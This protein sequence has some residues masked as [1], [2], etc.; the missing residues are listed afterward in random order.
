MNVLVVDS[1]GRGHCI[2]EV[3]YA[4]NPDVDRVLLAPGMSGIGKLDERIKCYPGARDVDSIVALAGDEEVG[5]VDIGAERWLTLGLVDRLYQEG[6]PAIGPTQEAAIVEGSKSWTKYMLTEA[7]G[8]IP[9]V[10]V[11]EHGCFDSPGTA[12]TYIKSRDYPV[13][14]KADG[15]AAG[16]G[17]IVCD[18]EGQAIKAAEDMMVGGI[19]GDAGK[20]VVVEKR[21]EGIE[22]SFYVYTDGETAKD[23]E[24]AHD[25]KRRFDPREFIP[26]ELVSECDETLR[27]FG[28]NPNTGGMGAYCPHQIIREDV[29]EKTMR[30]VVYPTLERLKRRGID[31]RGVLYFGL[32]LV[33]DEPHV[34]EINV[35]HGD[36]EAQVILP[37]LKTN[38]VELGLALHNQE[39]H[40]VN[41]EWDDRHYVD[42]VAVAGPTQRIK[43]G[44]PS[45]WHKGYPRTYRKGDIVSGLDVGYDGVMIFAAG[46]SYDDDRKLFLTDGGR[47]VHVVGHADPSEGDLEEARRRAYAAIGNIN[48]E[49]M[50]Y[51]KTIALPGVLH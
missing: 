25:N 37:K 11:A 21:L 41:M 48:F 28:G 5:L 24:I 16:K 47:V 49:G 17:S 33:D 9:E 23:L 32:M 38:M 22:Y 14:V 2:A 18:N 15:L 39:L 44:K 34:L 8:G 4:D 30:D 6:I 45:G 40:R 13:V 7:A 10:R 27:N 46:L 3:L 26:E 1:G 12:K 36:P 50:D 19:F 51:R 42:V 35:R 43:K 20:I 29:A 31:Y